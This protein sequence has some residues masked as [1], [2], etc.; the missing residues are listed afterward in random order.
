MKLLDKKFLF[1]PVNSILER[2]VKRYFNETDL[3]AV[4]SFYRH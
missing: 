2:G 1:L 3:F 4:V